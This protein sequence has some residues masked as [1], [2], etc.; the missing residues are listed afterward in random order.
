ML[1][2][3]GDEGELNTVTMSW[4]KLNSLRIRF[5]NALN[6]YNAAHPGSPLTDEFGN[7]VTFE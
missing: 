7:L 5:Q 4:A 3:L 1:E 2:H 6:E